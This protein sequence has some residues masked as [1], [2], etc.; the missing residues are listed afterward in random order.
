MNTSTSRK[1]NAPKPSKTERS[2]SAAVNSSGCFEQGVDHESVLL[3]YYKT[4]GKKAVHL[5]PDWDFMA[6]HEQSPEFETCTCDK[7]KL[8]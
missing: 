4:N 7:A 6:I 8:R 3:N 1:G 2:Q 5:C